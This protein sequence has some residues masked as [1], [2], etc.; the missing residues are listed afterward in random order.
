MRAVLGIGEVNVVIK[1]RKAKPDVPSQETARVLLLTDQPVLS[2]AVALTLKHG[3]FLVRTEDD[4]KVALSALRD[5][6]PHVI[7]ADMEMKGGIGI[8]EI[9]KAPKT[10]EVRTPIVVLTHRLDLKTRLDI[11]F[12]GADDVITRPF[13]PEELLARVMAVTRRAHQMEPLIKPVI[14][15]GALR[16]DIMLRH[17]QVGGA[18]YPAHGPRDLHPLSA[19][20]Q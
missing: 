8:S 19:G 5:W 18:R 7:V 16:I 20:S 13:A 12:A 4:Q 9:L 10:G 1:S 6:H 17:V 2:K 3:A 14:T 11:F 15:V